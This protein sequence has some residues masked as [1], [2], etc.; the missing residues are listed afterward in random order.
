[1]KSFVLCQKFFNISSLMN[2]ASIPK[3]EDV[4][5]KVSQ[6]IFEKSNNFVPGN[7]VTV[8]SHI[9]PA[10]FLFRRNSEA[11]DCRH[12]FMPVTVPQYWSLT[13]RCPSFTNKWDEEE[14]TLIEERQMGTKFLGF[15]LYWAKC[16]FSILQW[17][18]RFFGVL[19]SPVF[20]NSIRS[21]FEV[22]SKHQLV[23]KLSCNLSRLALQFFSMSIYLLCAQRPQ[24]PQE[25]SFLGILFPSRSKRSD[26]PTSYCFA[27]PFYRISCILGTILQQNSRTISVLLPQHDSF[28]L[29]GAL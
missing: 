12:L 6:Q 11:T 23:C 3:K 5:L 15:F 27:T 7:V 22:V 17:L 9:K 16:F 28:F 26:V 19:A 13:N 25:V 10:P 18:S 4:F 14:S 21:R 29:N 24:H 1:M 2:G 8:E 20:D